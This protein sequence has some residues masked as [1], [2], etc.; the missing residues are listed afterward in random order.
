M[1][2]H[3][4]VAHVARKDLRQ[5]RWMIAVYAVVVAAATPEAGWSAFGA[6]S[7]LLW[8]FVLVLTGMVLLAVLVQAD[9]P[10]RSTPLW[11]TLPLHPSAVFTAKLVVGVLV[12]LGLALVGQAV[13]L[14]A[15]AVS[16]GDLPRLLGRS[17]VAFGLWLGTA[18]VIAALAPDLRT[19]L[20]AL[21]LMT[22]GW[23]F[24]AQVIWASLTWPENSGPL[25]LF[26]LV[27]GL[28]CLVVLLAHQYLTR[29]IRRGVAAGALFWAASLLI[30]PVVARSAP[31]GDLAAGVVPDPVRAATIII[32]SVDFHSNSEPMMKIRVKGL[33]PVHNYVL[34]SPAVELRMEDGSS[35]PVRTNDRF[36]WLGHGVVRLEG[37]RWVNRTEPAQEAQETHTGVGLT[38]T[39]AQRRALEQGRARLSLRGRVEVREPRV[40]MELPLAAGAAG[41]RQGLRIRVT[42]AEVLAQGPS[43]EVRASSVAASRSGSGSESWSG[44]SSADHV[45]VNRSRGEGLVMNQR[46]SHSSEGG[47]VL[48]GPSTKALRVVLEPVG[49]PSPETGV[50]AGWLNG[51]HLLV[52]DW[53]PLGSYPIAIQQQSP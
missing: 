31:A 19:F 13:A 53:A 32:D 50:E 42:R 14:S 47:L 17:A 44:P 29:R 24:S 11:V 48:P 8:M 20:L 10:A 3:A 34:M 22:L 18:A 27:T 52:V 23:M 28:F 5:F 12:V 25:P 43:V 7:P 45:L 41:V 21:T 40:R 1:K 35:A 2:W 38:L 26:V 15:H 46:S 4:Q 36:V 33:S 37:I 9:S 51:A 49:T 6:D 39:P 30:P 16:A